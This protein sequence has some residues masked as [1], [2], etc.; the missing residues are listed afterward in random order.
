MW[1][2]GMLNETARRMGVR[3]GVAGREADTVLSAG[4]AM[5]AYGATSWLVVGAFVALATH[6]PKISPHLVYSYR[7]RYSLSRALHP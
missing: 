6:R 7:K 5:L 2:V 3:G 1:V 4:R